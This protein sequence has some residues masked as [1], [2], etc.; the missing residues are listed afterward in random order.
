M[1]QGVH[2]KI[3]LTEHERHGG[4]LLYEW[5]LERAK[6][7]GIPGGSAFRA[8]AGFGRHGMMHEEGFFELAGNL[9][10]QLE[11]IVSDV[12]ADQL[13]AMIKSAGLNLVFARMPVEFGLTRGKG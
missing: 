7:L 11:F 13:L 9:P 4:E 12:Q 2:L 1:N 10:V 6:K 3:F 5:L 8:I